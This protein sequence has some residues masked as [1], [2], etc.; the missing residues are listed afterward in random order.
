METL[1]ETKKYAAAN[2]N[3]NFNKHITSRWVTLEKSHIIS[4]GHE[5]TK[6]QPSENTVAV[7]QLCILIP[8]QF[9][10]ECGAS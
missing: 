7:P 9:P 4:L 6:S 10:S 8:E 5:R 1:A 2:F 3:S